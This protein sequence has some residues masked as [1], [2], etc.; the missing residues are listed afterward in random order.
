MTTAATT[1]APNSPDATASEPVEHPNH[2][3]LYYKTAAVLFVLTAIE[4]ALPLVFEGQGK[5][6]GPALIILM[7]IKFFTVALVFMH[8][9]VDHP[10]LGKLFYAGL[11]LAIMVYMA[12]LSSLVFWHNSGNDTLQRVPPVQTV[13]TSQA[14]GG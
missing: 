4:I 14:T 1:A 2:D 9:K 5:F 7:V 6:T 13:V 10:I 3:M 8:L 11:G 12:T